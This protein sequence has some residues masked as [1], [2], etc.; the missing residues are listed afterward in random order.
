MTNGLSEQMV[1][2][3]D[4]REAS[5]LASD[6]TAFCLENDRLPTP[7]EASGFLTRLAFAEVR[8]GQYVYRCGINARDSLVIERDAQGRFQFMVSGHVQRSGIEP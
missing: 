6:F 5:Y 3:G 1:A 2:R 8:G 7:D 4:V